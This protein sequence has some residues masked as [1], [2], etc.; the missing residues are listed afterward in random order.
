MNQ[1]EETQIGYDR[2]AICHDAVCFTPGG[3][4]EPPNARSFRDD[5]SGWVD[6][7]GVNELHGAMMV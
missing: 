2:Y 5:E 7:I 6:K 1:V 4:R 3:R